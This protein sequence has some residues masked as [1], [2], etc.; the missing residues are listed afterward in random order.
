MQVRDGGADK[1]V[2]AA[3]VV[4][5]GV[6]KQCFGSAPPP[7]S[8]IVWPGTS[9]DHS[10]IDSAPLQAKIQML[11]DGTGNWRNTA[12]GLILGDNWHTDAPAPAN[13]EDYEVE[14]TWDVAPTSGPSGFQPLSA[15]YEW[16]W[17]QGVAGTL[18]VSGNV[19]VREIADTGNAVVR[20][21]TLQLQ[22]L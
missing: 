21:Y 13:P 16:Q 12:G 15:S 11:N 5:G 4:E 22:A 18:N 19:T 20:P 17:D 8:E 2:I 14:V 6:A 1:P 10:E 3:F 9:W 7:P